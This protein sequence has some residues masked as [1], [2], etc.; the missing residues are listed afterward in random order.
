MYLSFQSSVYVISVGPI[1]IP[2]SFVDLLT[3]TGLVVKLV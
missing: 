3:A 1:D 2:Q